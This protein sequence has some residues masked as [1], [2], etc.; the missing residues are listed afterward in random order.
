MIWWIIAAFLAFFVK[1]V[2]GFANTLIFNSI[3]SFTVHNIQITPVELILGYPSNIILMVRERNKLEPSIVI[4]LAAM[5]LAGNLAG[6]FL[7]KRIDAHIIR[8]F[9]GLVVILVG[10]EMLT[11]K[12]SVRST[13]QSRL[14]MIFFGLLSGVFSGLYGVGALLGAYIGRRVNDSGSFRSNLCA[15]F[16]IENTFRII[17]YAFTGILTFPLFLT[18]LKLMPAM[19]AGLLCGIVCSRRIPEALLRKIISVLL[20]LSGI[21]LIAM[22]L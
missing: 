15:V 17:L 5:V 14:G 1:G 4:P 9:F 12:Q 10:L 7:L 18:A 3:L 16:T 13:P 20:I 22:N 21:M 11:R 8:L 2:S 6:V 19:L